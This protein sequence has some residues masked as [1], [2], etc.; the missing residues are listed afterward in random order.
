MK[1]RVWISFY[2][3]T[4]SWVSAG[5]PILTGA[6]PHAVLIEGTVYLY[7]T[8]GPRSQ[9]YVYS[10]P[11]LVDWQRHGPILDFRRIDWIG[12]RKSAWAPAM[13]EKDGTCYFFYSAGPKPSCIGVAS[14]RSPTGPFADSGRALL[15]DDND[16]NFEAIDPMVFRDPRSGRY[17]LYAGGS[18]GATLRVFELTDDLI[19]LKK[20]INVQTPPAFTEGVFMHCRNG[21]YYLSYSHGGWRD[22]SYSVHYATAKTPTGPWEYRGAILTSDDACKGPGHHSFVYNPAADQWY[23]FYHRWENVEGDGPYSGRREIAVDLAEFESDGRIKPVI[24]T[25]KGVGPVSFKP[26]SSKP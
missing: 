13:I 6:D 2:L 19:G 8:S 9:F 15:S 14:G 16:P 12:R 5:N 25:R 21:I 26:K 23:I 4:A 10:S 20:E 22:S 3:M 17:F 7:P 24:M 11:D 18:A 1:N